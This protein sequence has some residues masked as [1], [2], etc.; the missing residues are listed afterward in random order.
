MSGFN[1]SP[2][3]RAFIFPSSDQLHVATLLVL[4][5]PSLSRFQSR[6]AQSLELHSPVCG[7]FFTPSVFRVFDLTHRTRL[8]RFN[9]GRLRDIPKY[10][11]VKH[12]NSRYIDG[13]TGNIPATLLRFMNEIY[14]PPHEVVPRGTEAVLQSCGNETRDGNG[15]VA[16][17]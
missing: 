12:M 10:S 9:R 2:C 1:S 11:K 15:L 17:W 6:R 7:V 13:E 5:V 3:Y 16:L 4:G 8:F 14:E